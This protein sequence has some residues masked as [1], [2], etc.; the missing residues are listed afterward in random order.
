MKAAVQRMHNFDEDGD[1]KVVNE[2]QRFSPHSYGL[3][4]TKVIKKALY[5][6]LVAAVHNLQMTFTQDTSHIISWFLC[7]ATLQHRL[8]E[9]LACSV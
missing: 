7:A 9:M 3:G 2:T 8:P 4:N 5:I 6:R 1:R